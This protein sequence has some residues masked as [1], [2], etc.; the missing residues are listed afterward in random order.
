MRGSCGV[1]DTDEVCTDGEPRTEPTVASLVMLSPRDVLALGNWQGVPMDSEVNLRRA[2][3]VVT[4]MLYADCKEA[5]SVAAG[6]G[7]A[8]GASIATNELDTRRPNELVCI[9]CNGGEVTIECRNCESRFC[10]SCINLHW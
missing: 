2:R 4:P 6:K 5:V 7:A 9:E 8:A 1:K 3:Q 10:D